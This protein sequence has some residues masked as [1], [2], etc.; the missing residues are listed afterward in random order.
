MMA[1][2]LCA[3][4]KEKN[5]DCYGWEDFLKPEQFDHLVHCMKQLCKAELGQMYWC[6]ILSA[7]A[8]FEN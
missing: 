4:C 8:C 3:I 7:I 2:L 5:N 6:G 1:R